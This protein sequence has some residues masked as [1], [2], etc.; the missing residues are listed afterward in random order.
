MANVMPR[1]IYIDGACTA[2]NAR[3]RA[4]PALRR[5]AYGIF[6]V[7]DH[8]WNVGV[9]LPRHMHVTNQVAELYALKACLCK[10]VQASSTEEASSNKGRTV[11]VKTDSAYVVKIFTSWVHAWARGGWQRR[12]RFGDKN[13]RPQP[14]K[15]MEL[16]REIYDMLRQLPYVK[17]EHVRAHGPRPVHARTDSPEF[18]DWYGNMQA[19]RLA[20]EATATITTT[21]HN[22]SPLVEHQKNKL[23]SGCY[24]QT[25]V[26]AYVCNNV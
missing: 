9:A 10:I 19:D 1:V 7:D 25:R 12:P 24:V 14:I 18:M 23:L 4:N 22:N 13:T 6:V 8:P 20:R 15:N 16:I 5:A 2:N 26:D 17:L 3:G 21:H 11:V